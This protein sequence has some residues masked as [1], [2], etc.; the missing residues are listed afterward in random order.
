MSYTANKLAN[1]T[2]SSIDIYGITTS[3]RLTTSCNDFRISE[4][5]PFYCH[6]IIVRSSKRAMAAVNITLTTTSIKRAAFYNYRITISIVIIG[7]A[8]GYFP[9]HF[10]VVYC[11]GIITGLPLVRTSTYNR[12]NCRTACSIFHTDCYAISC[13]VAIR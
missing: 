1:T 9:S 4:C 7:I 5:P 3:T 13:G 12:T 2:C 11:N 10:T 8:A 6:G